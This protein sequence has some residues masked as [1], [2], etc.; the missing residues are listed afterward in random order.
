MM[1]VATITVDA[2]GR[3]TED[4]TLTIDGV[5]TLI[6]AHSGGG[7]L[8]PRRIADALAA[9]GYRP[10]TDYYSDLDGPRDGVL[11]IAVCPDKTPIIDC[12]IQAYE[13]ASDETYS[14]RALVAAI[15]RA[16]DVVGHDVVG[17][18]KEWAGM[19]STDQVP[20]RP[21]CL[22][23]HPQD[24]HAGQ[25]HRGICFP[26]YGA[27]DHAPGSYCPRLRIRRPSAQ[28]RPDPTQLDLQKEEIARAIETDGGFEYRYEKDYAAR[29]ARQYGRQQ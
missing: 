20:V 26:C 24:D 27:S 21:V 19:L 13:S 3:L 4:S 16:L 11:T 10:A 1:R 22:C 5:T 8:A 7:W 28:Q 25:S 14:R 18:G 29:I 6:P 9:R 23:G 2:Q 17:R 15:H 12:A